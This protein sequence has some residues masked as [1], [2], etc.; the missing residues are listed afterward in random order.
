MR[1]VSQK[2]RKM[3]ITRTIQS[4]DVAAH[5]V[6]KDDVAT[7]YLQHTHDQS[8]RNSETDDIKA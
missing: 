4:L 6:T 3:Q 2:D 8:E 5:A 7:H 1:D